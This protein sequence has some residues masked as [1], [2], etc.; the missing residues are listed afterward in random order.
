MSDLW[1][2]PALN[3]SVDQ[4]KFE[5]SDLFYALND[6]H[7]LTMMARKF[8]EDMNY[9]EGEAGANM[10]M[11]SGVLKIIS[12]DVCM[13]REGASVFDGSWKMGLAEDP[14]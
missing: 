6:L 12:D 3:I 5:P 9:P 7:H 2:I 1:R 4:G 8:M 13:I 11:L 10:H 14:R